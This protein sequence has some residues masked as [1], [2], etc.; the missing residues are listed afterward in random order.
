M[1]IMYSMTRGLYNGCYDDVVRCVAGDTGAEL[2]RQTKMHRRELMN[3]LERIFIHTLVPKSQ[4]VYDMIIET[5]MW[6]NKWPKVI[7]C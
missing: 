1:Y 3:R 4:C 6:G 2:Q 7:D 5:T